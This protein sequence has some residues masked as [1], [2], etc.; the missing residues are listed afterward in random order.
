MLAA[1]AAPKKPHTIVNQN[2]GSTPHWHLRLRKRVPLLG[3]RETEVLGCVVRG[4]VSER[5]ATLIA[6]NGFT[7]GYGTIVASTRKVAASLR[8]KAQSLPSSALTANRPEASQDDGDDEDT[9]TSDG[10][11]PLT[12]HT[13]SPAVP[14]CFTT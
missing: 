14:P 2:V 5:L 10:G 3:V 7:H 13:Q 9:D 12:R 4:Y 11:L 1:T 8:K 6:D